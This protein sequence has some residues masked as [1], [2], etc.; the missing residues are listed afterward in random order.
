MH[1]KKTFAI[2]AGVLLILA[3]IVLALHQ[4]GFIA[5]VKHMHGG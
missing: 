4:F 3:V 1:I 2:V 5:F